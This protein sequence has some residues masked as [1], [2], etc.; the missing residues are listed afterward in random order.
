MIFFD[1]ETLSLTGP[2]V[3]IQYAT[4]DG[5]ICIHDVW[6]NPIVDTMK[7]I[8]RLVSEPIVGFN[9]AFDWFQICKLYT[10]LSQFDDWSLYPS[11][12]IDQCAIFEEKGRF[13]PC[14][15]PKS[16][17]DLMLVA[18]R[19]PYQSTMDREPI[20]IKRVPV[21][22]AHN[23]AR[24]LDVRV[25]LNRVYFAKKSNPDIHWQ[26]VDIFDDVGEVVSDLKNIVL[27]FA[28]SSGL[29]A[30][31][32]DALGIDTEKIKLFSSVEIDPK[33]LPVEFGFAPYAMAIGKPGKWNGAWPE[34][35]SHH[36]NHW[37]YNS[38]AREYASDDV[39]YTRMLYHYFKEP[40]FDD[41][42]SV[43]ACMVAACRWRGYALDSR[44]IK[45][46]RYLDV[47]KLK[48]LRTVF[49]ANN[50]QI[51]LK[52]IKAPPPEKCKAYL[53]EVMSETERL[54]VR[55][56]TKGMILEEIS[57]WKEDKI[58]E[59]CKGQGC[60]AC[61]DGLI[62]S[63]AMHPA[64][65]RADEILQMRHIKKE[66][67]LYDKLIF[68]GRFHASLNVIGTLSSRMSG[69]DGLNPQGIKSAE[70]VRKCFTLADGNL[71]I[72]C[73]GDYDGQEITI[74]DAAYGD[75]VLHAK[76]VAGLKIHPLFGMKLFKPMTYD[77]IMATKGKPG[78]E[79]KYKRSKNGV[80]AMLYGGE[81]YTLISRVGVTQ[82][83]ATAAYQEW[84]S[85]YKV[86]GQKRKEIFERFCSMRQSGG[87]GTKVE[88]AEPDDYIESL[89]GFRRYF[90][91]ENRICKALFDLAEKPPKEWTM[92]RGMVTRRDRE[93]SNCGATRSALFAAAFA[94]QSGNMRAAANHVI[95]SSGATCTKGAEVALWKLQPSGV[96]E[97][98]VQPLNVHDEIDAPVADQETALETKRIIDEYNESLK[99]VIPLILMKWKIGLKSWANK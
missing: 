3:I 4:D 43:L 83:Q 92:I 19:G 13:G 60:L 91:L 56:S 96:S 33:F 76:L 45:V 11:E 99:S 9:L 85:E 32:Q 87:I 94:I 52:D 23:L 66:I 10:M 20:L 31:A 26:V 34:V 70:E 30:L 98:K 88:W 67:E 63:D 62:H 84:I 47:R 22:I 6:T 17:L 50:P 79:D 81:D 24:E 44:R 7:L 40:A 18:R 78:A 71:P 59:V 39:K 73:G 75:P 42:D 21:A 55:G 51:N 8:D 64:A 93:Q 12:H 16:C 80:F 72:L 68:A 38:R 2:A 46:M 48:K 95:Q 15:K 53:Y 65:V 86:W 89:F 58:C 41:P 1:S 69:A 25:P 36:I 29:K 57:K 90:T 14:L 82:E 5:P 54:V 49:Y 35:I 97:W 61:E 77:E 28:P 37:G 27:R 74:A